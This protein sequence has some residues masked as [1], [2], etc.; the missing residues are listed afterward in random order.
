[1]FGASNDAVHMPETTI[2]L[3]LMRVQ[4]LHIDLSLEQRR[5]SLGN[6]LHTAAGILKHELFLATHITPYYFVDALKDNAEDK[7]PG[8]SFFIDPRNQLNV[9]NDWPFNRLHAD[10]YLLTR[11]F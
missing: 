11:Y 4:H 6:Q 8:S 3:H 9:V 2:D 5:T 7:V 1:M 10:S